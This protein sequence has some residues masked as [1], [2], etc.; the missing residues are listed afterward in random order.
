MKATITW[1]GQEGGP[2]TNAWGPYV[3]EANKPLEGVTNKHIIEKAQA[4]RF[5]KVEVTE[6]DKPAGEGPKMSAPAPSRAPSPQGPVVKHGEPV[7]QAATG[8]TRPA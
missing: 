2:A 1:L 4:N 6:E 7:S 5:F 3:F 8:N